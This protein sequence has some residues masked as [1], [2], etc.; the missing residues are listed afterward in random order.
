MLVYLYYLSLYQHTVF[1][2]ILQEEFVV[3]DGQRWGGYYNFP[4]AINQ[5]YMVAVVAVIQLQGEFIH[6]HYFRILTV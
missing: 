2:I 6:I 3:G 1:N 5:P 4:L